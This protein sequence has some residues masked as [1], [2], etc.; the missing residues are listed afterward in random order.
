[1]AAKPPPIQVSAKQVG[2][3]I[4]KVP[5][6]WCG[7]GN[8]LR[9]LQQQQL[10]D[11]GAEYDCDRCG[12]IVQVLKIMTVTQVLVRQH[13]TKHHVAKRPDAPQ[14]ASTIHPSQLQR[15]R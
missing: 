8:D 12:R 5:C 14:Q 9:E 7:F 6:P 13:P 15:R 1:M 3:V 10:L 2:G 4:N 11:N